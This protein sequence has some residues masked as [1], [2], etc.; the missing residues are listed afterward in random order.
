VPQFQQGRFE[1]ELEA[2]PG[3][4]LAET[5]R[6]GAELQQL[7]AGQPGVTIST[8]WPARATGSTRTP[9]RAG[10]TSRACWWRWSRPA[11]PLNRIL[12]SRRCGRGRARRP[13]SRP[14]SPRPSCSVSTSRWRSKSRATIWNPC[15]RPA[16]RSWAGCAVRTVCGRGIQRRAGHPEV[17]IFFDQERAAALGL[18]VKQISDQG[19]RQVAR[20]CRHTLQL[21]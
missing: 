7:A 20:A 9:T 10:R 13:A 16:T 6:L 12:S 21:A 3:T 18:T 14:I 11:P 8:A 17:Q 2:A 5:D 19:G 15:A 4:P 1:V